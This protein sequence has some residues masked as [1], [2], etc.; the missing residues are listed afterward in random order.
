MISGEKERE[1]KSIL[2]G[3]Y[4]FQVT[5]GGN[6]IGREICIE[7]ATHGCHVAVLDLDVKAAEATCIYLRK[8]GV[9]AFAYKVAT[10]FLFASLAAE[11]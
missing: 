4:W 6:G 3:H 1:K 5:G 10:E 2:C 8:I 7:L 11:S 9:Q